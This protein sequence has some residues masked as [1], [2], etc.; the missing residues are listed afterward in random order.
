M[1]LFPCCCHKAMSLQ[2]PPS[3]PFLSKPNSRDADAARILDP[4]GAHRESQVFYPRDLLGNLL[5]P[6]PV[7]AP[8]S[9]LLQAFHARF[10]WEMPAGTLEKLQTR[11]GKPR[12]V[13][14]R[15]GERLHLLPT[16][17]CLQ[18]AVTHAPAPLAAI[19]P[20]PRGRIPAIPVITNIL[21]HL[22][23][24]KS[25]SRGREPGPAFGSPCSR[26]AEH[27]GYSSRM[28]LDEGMLRYS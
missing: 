5:L 13:L 21:H 4:A 27:E 19:V 7:T 22:N 8:A 18:R 20:M 10:R 9:P 11:S 23:R 16:T 14:G 6:S 26:G 2:V 25:P 24:W 17:S 1:E 12:I 3:S 28:A 15:Q